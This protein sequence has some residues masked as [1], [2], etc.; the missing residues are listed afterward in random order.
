MLY[1]AKNG[2]VHV[3]GDE[4]DYIVFGKGDRVMIMLPGIGDGLKTAQGM[5]LPFALMYRVFAKDFRVY[6]FSR[7]RHLP[8]G[9]TTRDMA[10]EQIAAMEALGIARADVVGVSMGGM[11]AQWMAIDFPERID[12]LV[13]AVTASRSNAILNDSISTWMSCTARKDHPA[14]MLDSMERMY[15]EGYMR[16]NRWLTPLATRIGKPKSYERFEIMASACLAH[17]AYDQLEQIK[18]ST[19]IIG[20]GKDKALGVGA[21]FEMAERIIGCQTMIYDEYGHAAYE[22]APDFN[23]TVMSFLLTKSGK[24]ED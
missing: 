3:N 10:R 6:V 1:N 24:T 18:S 20:G 12:R 16:A 9:Y 7:R 15:T 23:R 19:L 13:L 17:D 21:S 2:V 5:A 8:Q 14:L 11:I 4:M 22:E